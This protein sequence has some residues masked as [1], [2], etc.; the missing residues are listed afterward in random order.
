MVAD[1]TPRNV[2]VAGREFL[3]VLERR[4]AVGG[5][6]QLS[7]TGM[8]LDALDAPAGKLGGSWRNAS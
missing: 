2:R 8:S 4:P 3:A 7:H 5:E 1:P 6:T